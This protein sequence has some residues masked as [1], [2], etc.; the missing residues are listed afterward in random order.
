MKEI[1]NGNGYSTYIS[2]GSR[3]QK[4]K[5]NA[6]GEPYVTRHWER[7]PLDLFGVRDNGKA[8]HFITWDSC[9]VLELNPNCDMALVKYSYTARSSDFW[10]TKTA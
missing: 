1:K 2:R 9:I 7:Y 3:W 4:I 6:K 8:Y 10:T 5:Y